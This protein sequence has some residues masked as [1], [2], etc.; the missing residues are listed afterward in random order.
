M[1]DF[2]KKTVN[3][4][5]SCEWSTETVLYDSDG[6]FNL[7]SKGNESYLSYI[8]ND[9]I[10]MTKEKAKE[11]MIALENS[12]SK[13]KT[14]I[15][16]AKEFENISEIEE[17]STVFSDENEID[18]LLNKKEENSSYQ[19]LQ[20]QAHNHIAFKR[21][22]ENPNNKSAFINATGTG[23]SYLIAKISQHH[24]PKKIGILSSS[25][26]ILDQQSKLIGEVPNID[27]MTYNM[28]SIDI[29]NQHFTK[30]LDL[31]LM[32]EYHRSG[33][34]KWGE[35]VQNIIDSNEGLELVGLSA[36]NI[37]YLD[38][39]RNMADELFDGNIVNS[40]P[41]TTAIAKQILP[42]LTYV[43]GVYDIGKTVKD[44]KDKIN[45][46]F[47]D[48]E[49]KTK[50]LET[51]SGLSMDWDKFSNASTIISDNLKDYNGKYIVFCE[52][53]E[54]M[55]IMKT[56]LSEWI[57]DAYVKKHG[58]EF[59]S[60]INIFD[61][62]S[63]KSLSEN[64]SALTS[65]ESVSKDNGLSLLFTVDMLNEGKHV[66]GISG[67][68]LFRRTAS[69]ILFYQQI[70]RAFSASDDYN[71]LII[72]MVGNI[73]GIHKNLFSEEL[74][75]KVEE[76]NKKRELLGIKKV[77]I[78]GKIIGY[79]DDLLSKLS[80][81]DDSL[82]NVSFEN[83]YQL[84]KSYHK[85]RGSLNIKKSDKYQG[86]NIGNMVSTLRVA[87]KANRLLAEEIQQ[88]DALDFI[89]D[90]TKKY[91]IEN[92]LRIFQSYYEE[93]GHLNIKREEKYQGENIG[94]MLMM[95]R[96]AKKDNRLS[97]DEI[98][99]LKALNFVWDAGYK[100]VFENSFPLLQSYYEEHGHLN[101][102]LSD[103]Y[104][105]E[106]IGKMVSAV[107]AAKKANRLSTDKIQQLNALDF[108]W[109]ANKKSSFE[110]PLSLLQSYYKE[111]GHLNIKTSEKHHGQNIGK[112]I[113]GLRTT[114]KDN[115]ISTD[116]IQQL[117]ALGFVWDGTRKS[118]FENSFPL[119]NSYY[120]EH[121]HLNIMLPDKYE[122]ENIGKMVYAIRDT[123]RLNRLSAEEIQKLD[124]LNFIWDATKK[125]TFDNKLPLLQSYHQNHGHLN[126]KLSES[127]Q[128]ENIG[129]LVTRL[130]GDKKANK[131]SDDDI[132]KLNRLGFVWD[133]T[134]K[135][136]F[137]NAFPLLQSYYENYGNL[138]IKIS[139]KY[140][141]QNIGNM[142]SS[143]R[144]AK[145]DN[146]LSDEEIQKLDAL[147]FMWYANKKSAFE[148]ALPLLKSYYE[149]HGDL[150]IKKSDKYQG[151][152]I[153]RSVI[154][155][156][157]YKKDN[158][159]ST[160]EIQQL[161]ELDFNWGKYKNIDNLKEE[162]P[163]F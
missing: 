55:Q 48:G 72:D 31:L 57:K 87:K 15:L 83:K 156:R 49:N 26:F 99:K 66:K 110:E 21:Y 56:K 86:E 9:N 50:A 61:M 123:K 150:N 158:K 118:A 162:S 77:P 8:A 136:V 82:S 152:N 127:Y 101:I 74:T 62:H 108:I 148:V 40:L 81:I 60:S 2:N 35:G 112:I 79:K 96:V 34:E 105:G 30:D 104:H 78:E 111:H 113:S 149:E 14:T 144:A 133:A 73:N 65:F 132:Q 146:N 58:D 159:L 92:A 109:D 131:L 94:I 10:V 47:I 24:Y 43:T 28:A 124:A 161:D 163:E 63:H 1:I 6:E 33:A 54:H 71:P 102:K 3:Y 45:D 84:L 52:N 29:E 37:R 98:Q 18:Y 25:S 75:E 38:N 16:Y 70:G 11:K 44:Y 160:N 27:Y 137:E 153:G 120:Q 121:G 46:K 116:E 154:R 145:R 23:K 157:G 53:I 12:A 103:S 114:R 76:E 134:N 22:L 140:Q 41:L 85:E 93:H 20:L 122:G 130:R 97:T 126:I 138:D 125:S 129:G 135:S 141:G 39:Y 143:V 91:R 59:N 89:W 147:N 64:N 32:D 13:T 95:L 139:D 69:P 80:E 115:R 4:F 100:S 67:A 119:L 142:V 5:K 88:L 106:D 19:H 51:L 128:G 90:T 36:T 42:M 151:E 107:R 68:F 155:L 17:F 7:I 117:D